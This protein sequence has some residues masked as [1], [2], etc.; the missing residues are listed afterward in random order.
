MPLN[1]VGS[2][3]ERLSVWLSL[4]RRACELLARRRHHVEPAGIE[5]SERFAPVHHVQRGALA[6]PGLREGELAAFEVEHAPA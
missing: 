2:V 5:R 4:R 3:S 6:R 1:S